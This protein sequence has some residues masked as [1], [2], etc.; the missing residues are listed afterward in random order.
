MAEVL[1]APLQQSALPQP[2]NILENKPKLAPTSVTIPDPN[3]SVRN[4]HLNL[5][6]FSPVNQNGSFE[7]DRELKSGEVYKRTRKTRVSIEYS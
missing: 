6:V 4:G 7:F 2:F 5:D 3:T 1:R